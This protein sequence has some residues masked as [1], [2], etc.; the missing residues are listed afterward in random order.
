[1]IITRK[2]EIRIHEEDKEMKKNYL[3]TIFVWRDAIRMAANIIVSQK[4]VQRNVKEFAYFKPEILE[5][6]LE[7]NPDRRKIN[8]KSD[9]ETINF[10]VSDVIKK[11]KGLSEQNTTYRLVAG[12]LNGKVN[13]DMY[14]C[15]NQAICKTCKETMDDVCRGETTLRSYKNNIPMPFSAKALSNLHSVEEKYI[16]QQTG[17]EMK[18][19]RY[20]FT[21]FG[22]PFV[23]WLGRDRSNNDNNEAIILRCISG[24]YKI[25]SSSIA[26]EKVVNR[27][28]GKKKQKLFLYLCVDMPMQEIKMNE[29]KMMFCY[30][31]LAHPIEYNYEVQAKN[32]YDSGVKWSHIGDAEEFLY[33]RTQIQAAMHRC[34]IACKYNKGGKG[35]K[36]KLQALDRYAE[37]EKN[38]VHTKLHTYSRML[39]NEAIKYRCATI[40]LVNQEPRELQAK[41][42][43]Q[44]GEPFVLRNWSYYSLKTMIEYKAKMVGIKLVE[45][46]KEIPN[47][48]L[49]TE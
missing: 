6:F 48:E 47:E 17:K 42:D 12:L 7:E 34:Q 43:N 24:E 23:C 37:L 11:E 4:F 35:R 27:E 19:N 3:H 20:Y 41:E 10:N 16:V 26:F 46:G 32:I 29:K 13:S 44:K 39:V 22:I 14:S 30:L 5:K 31:G 15:L 49:N 40:V 2:I 9:K 21:L 1:M 45:V 36:R 18:V 28:T 8:S 38:Y 25:K 33:R